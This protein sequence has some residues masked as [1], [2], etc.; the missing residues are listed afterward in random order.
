MDHFAFDPDWKAFAEKNGLPVPSNDIPASGPIEPLDIDFSQFRPQQEEADAEWAAKHPFASVGYASQIKPFTVRGGAQISAKISYPTAER[1]ERNGYSLPCKLPVLLVTHGGGWVSGSH[2]SEEIWSLWRLVADLDIITIS[3]DYRLAPENRFPTWVE[4]SWDVLCELV[5][6]ASQF[7][8]ELKGISCDLSRLILLGSSAG[9]YITAILAQRCRDTSKAVR[10]VVL[11]V[12]VLCHFQ[13]FPNETGT[14]GSFQQCKET[15]L[16]S[17]EMAT[18][19]STAISPS[20]LGA[21]PQVSPLLGILDD[22]APHLIFVAGRDPLRDEAILYAKRLEESNVSVKLHVYGGVPH[23]F[24]HY[25]ELEATTR[26]DRE[27]KG[28]LQE[29][30]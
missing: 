26:F 5:N 1:L 7:T 19:W 15:F 4:D 10:G 13:H 28:G 17:R 14:S 24:A 27:L 18:C 3:V 16:G 6:N 25:G 29:W 22:L 12:P 21:D 23:N 20:D 11:N 30:I 2:V 9:A 8:A